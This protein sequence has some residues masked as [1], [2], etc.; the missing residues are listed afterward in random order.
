MDRPKPTYEV[1]LKNCCPAARFWYDNSWEALLQGPVVNKALYLMARR[2]ET[3][4]PAPRIVVE[5]EREVFGRRRKRVALLK[6]EDGGGKGKEWL[7]TQEVR[8]KYL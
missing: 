6:R 7:N 5:A 3:W 8:M 2:R 1:E 4:R